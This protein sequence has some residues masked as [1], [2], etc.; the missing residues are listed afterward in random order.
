[1]SLVAQEWQRCPIHITVEHCERIGRNDSEIRSRDEHEGKRD[2][3]E[4]WALDQVG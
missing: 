1:M 3:I 2:K 4:V